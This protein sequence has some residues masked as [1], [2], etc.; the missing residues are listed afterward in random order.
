M[1]GAEG[2]G[3]ADGAGPKFDRELPPPWQPSNAIIA[4]QM[5]I[6]AAQFRVRIGRSTWL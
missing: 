2:A 5:P 1:A 3:A 4:A 6:R